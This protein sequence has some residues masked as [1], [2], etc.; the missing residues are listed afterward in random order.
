MAHFLCRASVALHCEE[1]FLYFFLAKFDEFS[2]R[3]QEKN[4]V[5]GQTSKGPSSNEI[6]FLFCSALLVVKPY[7]SPLQ[8]PDWLNNAKFDTNTVRC[9]I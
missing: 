4:K 9:L 6:V 5:S 8:L 3:F 2:S 1:H 7:S